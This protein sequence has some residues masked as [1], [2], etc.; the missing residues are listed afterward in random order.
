MN[1]IIVFRIYVVLLS[2]VKI[3]LCL[4]LHVGNSSRVKVKGISTCKLDLSTGRTLFLHDVL[5]ASEIRQNLVSII[6]LLSL[7]FKLYFH[8]SVLE[9]YLGTTF[10]GSDFLLD[11]FMILDVKNDVL[12]G[13]DKSYY[14][15]MTSSRNIYDETITWHARLGHIGQD[16]MNRLA[17][18]NLLGQLS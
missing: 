2:L 11:G 14:S 4:S 10:I 13:T 15:L 17:K 3:S 12:K 5:H 9:L 18:E 8:D 16:R 1:R 6:V 7:G